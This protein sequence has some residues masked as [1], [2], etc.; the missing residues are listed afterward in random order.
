MGP[1]AVLAIVLGMLGFVLPRSR[2][3]GVVLA[4]CLYTTHGDGV[5]L[6]ELHFYSIRILI[7]FVL[8]RVVVRG[9][10][11]AIRLR[12][13]D[14]LFFAWLIATNILY[15]AFDGSYVNFS[16]RLGDMYDVGGLY[17]IVR[18]L[19]RNIDDLA[20][21]VSVLAVLL[22][23]V[24]AIMAV[25]RMTGRNPFA[26]LGGVDEWSVI[27]NGIV[28]CQGPFKHSI[29]AGTS[30]ATAFPLLIGLLVLRPDRRILWTIA[31]LSAVLIVYLSGSSGPLIAFIAGLLG[32]GMWW[33]RTLMRLVRWVMLTSIIG[34]AMVM[35]APVWFII[36]RLSELSGGDGWYR[37]ALIDSAVRHFNEWWLIGTGYTAHWMPTG[38]PASP[39]SA[40]IVNEFVNQ[41]IRG[42]LLCLLLFVALLSKS[43]AAI[44]TASAAAPLRQGYFCWTVGCS[45]AAHVFSFFSVSY[46]DQII[47]FYYLVI[48]STVMMSAAR[49]NCS[50][51]ISARANTK[52]APRLGQLSREKPSLQYTDHPEDSD[53]IQ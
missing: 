40:D 22:I 28:R 23:P 41:G 27:R 51:E 13:F 42:G 29:L 33:M 6:G 50:R 12:A 15:V 44:G 5:E 46:F 1:N 30:G 48:G 16:E 18:A 52:L 17:I 38:I 43:F 8:I 35:N 34:L 36:D 21:T 14:I 10:L 26:A 45:L 11:N 49:K 39:Y 31:S 20:G 53:H 32:L 47:S 7:L 25:E 19:I 3:F 24:A 9:E 4:A 37:S 2:A